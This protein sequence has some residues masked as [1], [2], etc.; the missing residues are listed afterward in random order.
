V[1]CLGG[2][3]VIKGF[4]KGSVGGLGVLVKVQ[5][6]G[7]KDL[8]LGFRVLGLGFRAQGLGRVNIA[9]RAPGDAT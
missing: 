3:G 7:S 1:L 5:G 6:L 8:G 2:L 9:R 4:I